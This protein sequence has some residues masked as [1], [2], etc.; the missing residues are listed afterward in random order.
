MAISRHLAHMMGGDVTVSSQLG[1]GSVFTV[2]IILELGDEPATTSSPAEKTLLQSYDLN[3]LVVEDNP[4]NQLVIRGYLETI[5]LS[6]VTA[7]NGQSALQLIHEQ[8]FDIVFMDVRLPVMDG[9]ETTRQ[10]RAKETGQQHIPIVAL[11]ANAFAEDREACLE[12]GMDLHLR[13]PMQLEDLQSAI[14][15]LEDRGLMGV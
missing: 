3:V 11:T 7:D 1:K 6:V 4:V 9:L 2:K 12:A 10:I 15:T 5:G 14:A 13:K 8:T